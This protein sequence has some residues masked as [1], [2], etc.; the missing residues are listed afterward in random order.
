MTCDFCA[1]SVPPGQRFC[2]DR[3]RAAWHRENMP[4]GIVTG[5]RARKSGGYSVTVHYATLPLSL[6][7]GCTAW[8]E[9]AASTRTEAHGEAE[10]ESA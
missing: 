9:N 6:K 3:H 5:I 1:K 2:C 8:V 7:I 10:S 4:H